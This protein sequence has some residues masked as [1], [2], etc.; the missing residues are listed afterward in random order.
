MGGGGKGGGSEYVVGYE[1]YIGAHMVI[2]HRLIN[3]CGGMEMVGIAAGWHNAYLLL[4]SGE[5]MHVGKNAYNEADCESWEGIQ[6]L[7]ASEEFVAGWNGS[8]VDFAGTFSYTSEPEGF[9]DPDL[10]TW[11]DLTQLHASFGKLVGLTGGGGVRY[12]SW[13]M[14]KGWGDYYGIYDDIRLWTDITK[15]VVGEYHALGL[16]TDGTVIGCGDGTNYYNGVETWTDVIDIAATDEGS[17]GVKSDGTVVAVDPN[18]RNPGFSSWTDITQIDAES[19]TVLGR[20]SDGTCILSG[21]NCQTNTTN[22]GDW[23]QIAE[24]AVSRNLALG[25]DGCQVSACGS[26]SE[27]VSAEVEAEFS[28]MNLPTSSVDRFACIRGVMSGE[29]LAWVGQV[30]QGRMEIDKPELHGGD[31][32][33]GGISG[34]IDILSG[35]KGQGR[36]DY[37]EAMQGAAIP[38]YHGV[39]SAVY[40]NFMICSMNPYPKPI[41]YLVANY[42]SPFNPRRSVVQAFDGD[43]NWVADVGKNPA[44]IIYD[45]L[46]GVDGTEEWGLGWTRD[47]IDVES[48]QAA[49]ETMYSESLGLNAIW[50]R[51]IEAKDF[52]DDVLRY[53]DG[54]LAQDPQTGKFKLKL[55]RDDYDPAT[56]LEFDETNVIKVVSCTRTA[57][58]ELVNQVVVRWTQVNLDSVEPETKRTTIAQNMALHARTGQVTSSTIDF[59]YVTYAPL[60]QALAERELRQLSYPLTQLELECNRDAVQLTPGDRLLFSWSDYGINQMVFRVLEVDHGTPTDGIMRLRCA[61]D[62]LG[63]DYAQFTGPG[64]GGGVIYPVPVD[65]PHQKVIE[66][67]YYILVVGGYAT[68]DEIDR[69]EDDAGVAVLLAQRPVAISQGYYLHEWDFA[70]GSYANYGHRGY[71][72][73][74]TLVAAISEADTQIELD[75]VVQMAAIKPGE[76]ALALI[77]DEVVCVTAGESTGTDEPPTAGTATILRGCLDT[78]PAAHSVGARFWFF[79]LSKGGLAPKIG[80]QAEQTKIKALTYT[81]AGTLDLADA[82]ENT[83]TFQARIIRPYPVAN[84]AINGVEWPQAGDLANYADLTVTW[85]NRNRLDQTAGY[86]V[87]QDDG[88]ITP[89]AGTTC[90]LYWYDAAT[91]A[92]IRTVT[93]VAATDRIWTYTTTQEITDRGSDDAGSTMILEIETERDGW[94]SWQ[95]F[96]VDVPARMITT[97]SGYGYNYGNHYGGI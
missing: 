16:K 27:N 45:V 33:E 38:E 47:D 10:S 61:E 87:G 57:I 52:I 78:V 40:R 94:S 48:F 28:Y 44:S 88:D 32:S 34:K 51:G 71:T 2:C 92:L 67:P 24:I 25:L 49:A 7:A 93:G 6:F 75:N 18:N 36:N 55:F 80:L 13:S 5:V 56:L 73:T 60:A 4:S 31:D 42:K 79:G 14:V 86:V 91:L 11:L 22:V 68:V 15:V 29:K 43:G 50:N 77:D 62:V 21:F 65:C 85:D 17:F 37:L 9:P 41:K 72:P 82:S 70:A 54:K 23:T 84:V 66:V 46:T 63:F 26:T 30:A 8:S 69:Q 83:Y 58:D 12:V 53:M 3:A 97:S 96:T 1:Y 39:L 35:E 20:Q 74:G 59:P 81:T 19:G 89:E 76:T 95:R 90:N 64:D